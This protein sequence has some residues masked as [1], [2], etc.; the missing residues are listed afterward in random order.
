MGQVLNALLGPVGAVDIHAAVG[1]SNGSI[2]Q[3]K[4][5]CLWAATIDSS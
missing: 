3:R 2:L 1:V 5:E 4:S